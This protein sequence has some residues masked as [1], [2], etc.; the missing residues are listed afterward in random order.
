ME[1]V[2]LFILIL[3]YASNWTASKLT[4]LC[5]KNIGKK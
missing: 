1:D 4:F 3:T 5:E 2:P